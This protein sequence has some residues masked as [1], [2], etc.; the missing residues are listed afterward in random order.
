M[1]LFISKH[2]FKDDN[3]LHLASNYNKT[4]AIL[5]PYFKILIILLSFH[6][7]IHEAI[8]YLHHKDDELFNPKVGWVSTEAIE[9]NHL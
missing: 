7:E 8:L 1:V 2:P 4:I 6:Y 9:N 5:L 3:Q